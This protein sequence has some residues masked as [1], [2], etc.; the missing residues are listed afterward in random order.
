MKQNDECIPSPRY[1]FHKNF[2]VLN[3]RYFYQDLTKFYV[4]EEGSIPKISF[5]FLGADK[6][7]KSDIP[8]CEQH[9]FV[10]DT[11]GAYLNC[12]T[13]KK[14]KEQWEKGMK[15]RYGTDDEPTTL[16]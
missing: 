2:S 6:V 1:I 10:S 15:G 7:I 12:T 8:V 4:Y 9:A 16:T 14:K 11:K 3:E 13:K 5:R